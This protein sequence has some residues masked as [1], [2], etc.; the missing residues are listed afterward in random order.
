MTAKYPVPLIDSQKYVILHKF[1]VER[2]D[3]EDDLPNYIVSFEDMYGYISKICNPV[4]LIQRCDYVFMDYVDIYEYAIDHIEVIEVLIQTCINMANYKHVN[5]WID[6]VCQTIV[7][8]FDNLNYQYLIHNRP[9]K[10]SYQGTHEV[11]NVRLALC[12]DHNLTKFCNMIN[13]IRY[14]PIDKIVEL[15]VTTPIIEG[16]DFMLSDLDTYGESIRRCIIGIHV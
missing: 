14:H 15:I 8:A 6:R 5:R 10:F 4:E 13:F 9:L 3:D 1:G 7:S 2:S 11:R 12:G 16:Y